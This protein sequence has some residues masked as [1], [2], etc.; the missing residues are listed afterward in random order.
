MPKA[1]T[2][3]QESVHVLETMLESGKWKPKNH[4]GRKVSSSSLC[5]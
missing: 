1:F 5:V 3:G 2:F 4:G